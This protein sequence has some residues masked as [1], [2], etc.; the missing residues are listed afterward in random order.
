M[1][2]FPPI[3][4][5]MY[6]VSRRHMTPANAYPSENIAAI[7]MNPSKLSVFGMQNTRYRAVVIQ[8]QILYLNR[9]DL[10]SH[11]P[12]YPLWNPY[13]VIPVMISVT[14]NQASIR[15]AEYPDAVWMIWFI[16][17]RTFLMASAK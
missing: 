14:T 17:F 16:K 1:N 7:L 2:T 12:L 9:R 3:S 6:S 4:K 13:M 8:A 11:I 5:S 15:I 10:S